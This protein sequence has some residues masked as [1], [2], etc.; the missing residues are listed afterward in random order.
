MISLIFT[1]SVTFRFYIKFNDLKNL[2]P[3]SELLIHRYHFRVGADF[4]HPTDT[5]DARS[6]SRDEV[7][8]ATSGM[9]LT[10]GPVPALSY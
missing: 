6:H 9:D 7:S 1:C 4:F 2:K 8:P 5:G 3:I 10:Q